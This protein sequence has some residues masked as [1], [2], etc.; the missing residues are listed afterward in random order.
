MFT[1][2]KKGRYSL[3]RRAEAILESR[4]YWGT[5]ET[6]PNSHV[7]KETVESNNYS[8]NGSS[9]NNSGSNATSPCY[10]SSGS[11]VPSPTLKLDSDTNR[12]SHQAQQ[13]P[14][15]CGNN[16]LSAEDI[17]SMLSEVYG[18]EIVATAAPSSGSNSTIDAASLTSLLSPSA[19]PSAAQNNTTAT[20]AA[21]TSTIQPNPQFELN[22]KSS[23]EPTTLAETKKRN[24]F[25]APIDVTPH[26]LAESEIKQEF[27]P[28]QFCS[29]HDVRSK[30]YPE[31]PPGA[32][33]MQGPSARPSLGPFAS[34]SPPRMDSRC[35]S[36]DTHHQ[37]EL[38]PRKIQHKP[39]FSR[40]HPCN[41]CKFLL[42]FILFKLN[43]L[44]DTCL[45]YEAVH[46][47]QNE[48]FITIAANSVLLL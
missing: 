31:G 9:S 1:A 3:D 37:M 41:L 45:F 2:V 6:A 43:L 10:I 24:S 21:Y 22:K 42:N 47:A 19:M 32:A 23:L 46:C 13:V 5:P 35:P 27:P 18:D 33:G 14:H 34:I 48:R 40:R 11:S 29:E 20:T 44:E 15:T 25:G 12:A 28:Q 17:F 7:K 30:G 39:R 4:Q 16:D 38:Q 36:P 8:N 26:L